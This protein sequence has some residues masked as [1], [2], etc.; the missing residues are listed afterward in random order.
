MPYKPVKAIAYALLLWILGFI[1]GSIVFMTPALRATKPIPYI[2]SNPAISFPIIFVWTVLTLLL[3]RNY[4]KGATDRD[5]EGLKLGVTFVVVNF[6]LDLIVLVF[7]LQA[8]SKYFVS[9]S[10]WFA[11]A[12]LLLIPW[13]VGRSK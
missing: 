7:L 13:I 5:N 6:L 9:A 10:V 1:W 3:A 8:G 11:Y 4:L 2:S 12:T